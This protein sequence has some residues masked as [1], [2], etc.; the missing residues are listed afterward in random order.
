MKPCQPPSLNS[1]IANFSFCL[2]LEY[3]VDE[4]VLGK[5]IKKY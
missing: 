1:A 3:I 4:L 2:S 5:V